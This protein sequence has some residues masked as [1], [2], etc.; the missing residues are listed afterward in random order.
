MAKKGPRDMSKGKWTLIAPSGK[1]WEGKLK[2]KRFYGPNKEK[3]AIFEMVPLP[4]S[5]RENKKQS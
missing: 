3:F 2:W 5:K 1:H 4:E